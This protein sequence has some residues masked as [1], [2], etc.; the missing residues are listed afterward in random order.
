MH[1]VGDV[2]G[3]LRG[4]ARDEW[5]QKKL[6]PHAMQ[7]ESLL[8]VPADRLLTGNMQGF[9][10]RS[11][12]ERLSSEQRTLLRKHKDL[13]QSLQLLGESPETKDSMAAL[14]MKPPSV[15]LLSDS[16]LSASRVLIMWPGSMRI[17]RQLCTEEP[18]VFIDGTGS[19]VRGFS[20]FFKETDERSHVALHFL[21]WVAIPGGGSPFVAL[22]QISSDQSAANLMRSILELDRLQH[23]AFGNAVKPVRVN[24]DCGPALLV[25]A[26]EGW[27][28]ESVSAYLA[29]AWQDLRRRGW[30][31]WSGR[32]IVSWCRRHIV[33]SI[34]RWIRTCL[35]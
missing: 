3:Q 22:E 13:L 28:K 6:Q 23:A 25:A 5:R 24:V 2:Y 17:W 21:F 11:A 19:L 1:F 4:K 32:C 30:I 12:A 18:G 35:E 20:H 26:C 14:S 33:E 27:N 9:P 10:G 31:D 15:V 7:L 8:S 29:F 16:K 34:K